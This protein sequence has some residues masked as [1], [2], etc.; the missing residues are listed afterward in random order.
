MTN[1]Q[2]EKNVLGALEDLK[3]GQARLEDRQAKLENGQTRLENGQ[4][5]LEA[6][7][8]AKTDEI[9]AEIHLNKK[10]TDQSFEEISN[11]IKRVDVLEAKVARISR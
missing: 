8:D 11:L 9:I 4:T 3:H 1:T 5:R 7:I 10:Y 2:F 6:K